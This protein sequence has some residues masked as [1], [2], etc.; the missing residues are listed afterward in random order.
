MQLRASDLHGQR[1]SS[2]VVAG[3]LP[4]ATVSKK[5]RRSADSGDN[6]LRGPC[7]G[8]SQA[9]PRKSSRSPPGSGRRVS[10]SLR[11]RVDPGTC[12]DGRRSDSLQVNWR[13]G[14][15][16][17]DSRS[18]VGAPER[19]RETGVPITGPKTNSR[20][21]PN[22]AGYCFP[23]RSFIACYNRGA[24]PRSQNQLPRLFR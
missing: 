1:M 2:T 16:E 17:K 21:N 8:P 6:C 20:Q 19:R 4:L 13:I 14:L 5:N 11:E 15:A 3:H 18:W 23:R 9:D 24:P 10:T 12:Q 7:S 22:F